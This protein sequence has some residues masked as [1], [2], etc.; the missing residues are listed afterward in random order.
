M[1][2]A[3]FL[4]RKLKSCDNGR[5]RNTRIITGGMEVTVVCGQE[6]SWREALYN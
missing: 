3:I 1:G 6:G 4:K 2:A 5:D